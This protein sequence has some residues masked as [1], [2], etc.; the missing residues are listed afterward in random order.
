M[1]RTQC[2]LAC[3]IALAA[4]PCAIGQP[5]TITAVSVTPNSGS[6]L[7]QTFTVLSSDNSGDGDIASVYLDIGTSGVGEEH[8]CFVVWVASHYNG[9]SYGVFYLFNDDNSAALGPLDVGLG[10]SLSNSQCTISSG[11]SGQVSFTSNS[12]TVSFPITFASTYN[13]QKKVYVVAQTVNRP[14]VYQSPNTLLGTWT[15]TQKTVAAAS[16]SPINGSGFNPATFQALYTDNAGAA[17]IQVVYLIFGSSPPIVANGCFVAYVPFGNALY[18]FNDTDSGVVANSPITAGANGT[19]SNSQCTLSA[20]GGTAT[21]QGNNFT[22]RFQITFQNSFTGT[23]NV[24][25][26]AQSYD[27]TQSAWAVLGTWNP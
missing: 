7:T 24:Y 3:W 8:S 16:I 25:G 27:G 26:L 14:P 2:W 13:G 9:V 11:G 20:T 10:G 15:P 22:A 19:L 21:S 18:L 1:N 17:D 6:G 23:H 5:V 4:L 12:V